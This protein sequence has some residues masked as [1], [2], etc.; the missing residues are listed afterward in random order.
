M[1]DDN[2]FLISRFLNELVLLM[3]FVSKFEH[4]LLV[5]IDD[6]ITEE[7]VAVSFTLVSVV[8]QCTWL[9]HVLQIH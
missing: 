1:T 5:H 9:N 7:N 6:L 2:V 4:L 8:D 3:H